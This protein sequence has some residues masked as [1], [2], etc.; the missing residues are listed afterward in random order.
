MS[1]EGQQRPIRLPD[2]QAAK[3]GTPLVCLTAY[4]APLAALVNDHCD[5]VLVGDSLGMV[6]HGLD[7]TVG[8]TMEMM[9][10]HGQAVRR[11]LTRPLMVVDLPFGAYEGSKEKALENAARLM[12]ETGCE[13]IKLEGGEVMAPTIKFLTERGIPVMAHIGLTPQ[14]VHALGG[15]R[16]QGRGEARDKVLADA[17]AVEEAGAFAVV[18]EK[19]T[20]SLS[21]EITETIS[22]PTIGIGA[23]ADC[24]GQI[25]VTADMLG[26]FDDFRPK[27]VKV[28]AELGQQ[29]SEALGQYADDVR[30]RRFPG[31]AQ[32][33][34]DN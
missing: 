22:I 19:V 13:A 10:L 12:A 11:K 29:V 27:F 2:I 18:L 15:Y 20:A 34:K 3:G 9:I 14:T 4:T 30:H 1:K 23:S 17:R 33:F 31:D 21:R 16:V 5:I 28:Y 32:I 7:T 8:V 24:D 6:V 26:L 25:L